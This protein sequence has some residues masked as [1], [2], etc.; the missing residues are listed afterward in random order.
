MDDGVVRAA[1][2]RP[3]R[4]YVRY[5]AELGR[6]ILA[7]VAMGEALSAVCAEDG[8]PTHGTVGRWAKTSPKFGAALRRAR[9]AAGWRTPTS[10]GSRYC[11]VA[12]AEIYGR[13]CEGE[14]LYRICE[15]PRMPAHATV[16]NWRAKEP[17]FAAALDLARQVAAERFCDMGWEIA[18][19]VTPADAYATHVKLLQL[20]WN[21]GAMDPGRYG[22]HRP[23]EASVGAAR[24]PTEVIFSAR[25]FEVVVGPDGRKRVAEI[26]ELTEDEAREGPWRRE[27]GPNGQVV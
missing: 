7:R 20:R 26:A 21:A 18:Q 19:A 22:R 8:M 27:R 13:L 10:P 25:H 17:E 23:V 1:G 16:Y 15:D 24:E 2:R 4:S 3:R 6:A 14:A 11:P 5:S 9:S 12:A